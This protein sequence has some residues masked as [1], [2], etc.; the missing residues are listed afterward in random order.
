MALIGAT[1]HCIYLEHCSR[2]KFTVIL[3]Y[4]IQLITCFP[5]W[6]R[7]TTDRARICRATVTPQEN[8]L[9]N[10]KIIKT[11]HNI[12]SIILRQMSYI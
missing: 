3:R 10:S 8:K 2:S 4:N 9:A 7:T 6:I 1:A 5:A 12:N 11:P